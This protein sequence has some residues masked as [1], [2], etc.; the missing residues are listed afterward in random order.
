MSF[1]SSAFQNSAFQ[2]DSNPTPAGGGYSRVYRPNKKHD[3]ETEHE[4][5]QRAFSEMVDL[6]EVAAGV[7]EA[8][9]QE[10]T[11][12]IA[13][14]KRKTNAALEEG[15]DRRQIIELLDRISAVQGDNARKREQLLALDAAYRIE[16]AL[17]ARL[18]DDD[19]AILVLLLSE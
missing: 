18:M 11:A 12:T 1:Q 4:R 2:T 15:D 13:A 6:L 14:L 7:T 19:E 5:R 3:D 16:A 10:K 8:K 17:Q 9:P